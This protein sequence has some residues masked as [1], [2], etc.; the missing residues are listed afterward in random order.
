MSRARSGSIVSPSESTIAILVASTFSP[1]SPL[2]DEF[3]EAVL[4]CVNT[5]VIEY[6]L[7]ALENAKVDEIVVICAGPYAIDLQHYLL[8]KG[9]LKRS[10]PKISTLVRSSG[11]F[12]IVDA[13]QQVDE[14]LQINSTVLLM[15]GC[16]ITNAQLDKLI[17]HHRETK[18][19]TP[20]LG[21]TV[22][23]APAPADVAT[24]GIMNQYVPVIDNSNHLVS[25]VSPSISVDSEGKTTKNLS[26]Q[27]RVLSNNRSA[28][29]RSD[30]V[31]TG[32]SVITP[33]FISSAFEFID[34]RDFAS[35]VSSFIAQS[36]LLGM[37]IA[38]REMKRSSFYRIDSLPSFLSCVK[39]MCKRWL[40]PV[41]PETEI[42][43]KSFVLEPRGCYRSE[44]VR[45]ARSSSVGRWSVIDD[46]VVVENETRILSSVVKQSCKIG[47]SSIISHSFV[48]ENV[49]IGSNVEVINSLIGSQSII[50]DGVVI[51]NYCTISPNVVLPKG[52][53]LEAGTVVTLMESEDAFD[54]LNVEHPHTGEIITINLIK[55]KVNEILEKGSKLYNIDL[56]HRPLP[57]RSDCATDLIGFS[58]PFVREI[59]SL[60]QGARYDDSHLE[61]VVLEV[62]SMRCAH[63]KTPQECV[64]VLLFVII[65]LCLLSNIP[66]FREFVDVSPEEDQIEE[67][68]SEIDELIE[69]FDTVITQ[70]MGST[71]SEILNAELNLIE[72]LI[73]FADQYF[74]V[75]L[76]FQRLLHLLYNNDVLSEE[77][78]TTWY[79]DAVDSGDELDLKFAKFCEP[80]IDWLKT[81]EEESESD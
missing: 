32:V 31:Y 8:E 49:A 47:K 5:N 65:E 12:T 64:T 14:S 70:F 56:P 44:N 25:F 11:L 73:D 68:I 1:Y 61:N 19:R 52:L 80:F 58:D 35:L 45:I 29:I 17:S 60:I 72:G 40:F 24:R 22:C 9:H 59:Y 81:A 54:T 66:N 6:S 53:A 71:N 36:Y 28:I 34:A 41:S 48:C 75:T 67:V 69:R 23:F 76:I 21:A 3:H 4:P 77:S 10:S 42:D 63:A 39:S 18:K 27:R 51:G 50:S 26:L 20:S 74:I 46:D 78:I 13:L 57:F 15:D 7:E 30:L 37:T 62:H 55:S 79:N 2:S 43:N 33:E 16:V 38:T